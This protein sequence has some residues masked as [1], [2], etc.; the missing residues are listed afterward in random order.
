MNEV[1]F[2]AYPVSDMSRAVAFYGDILGLAK[3]E[4]ASDFWVEFQVGST[5]LGLGN[6]PEIG[7][8]GTAQSLALQVQ[9]LDGLRARLAGL[10]IS[11]IEPIEF[12][13]CRISRVCDPDG[14]QILFH[15]SK[16]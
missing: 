6:F 9:D 15:E 3:G 8:P 10:Q 14:N 1:A 2:I 11:T 12:P 13:S 16:V 4:L 7:V 5:T